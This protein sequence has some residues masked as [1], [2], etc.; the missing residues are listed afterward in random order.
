MGKNDFLTP[1]AIANRIKSKGLQKLRWYCQLCQ[2]QCRDE[3]GFKCHQTSDGHRRQMEL[4]GTNAHRVVEGY[5]EE[6]EREFM[7]HLKRA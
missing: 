7:D 6:F 5:S 2:K 3:N 1:K 4:F